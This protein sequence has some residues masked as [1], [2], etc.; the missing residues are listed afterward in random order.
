M[1][2]FYVMLIDEF[3]INRKTLNTYG[4][5]KRGQPGRLLIRTL[6]FKMSFIVAQS[7]IRFDGIIGTKDSFNQ[8]KYKIFLQELLTKFKK[9]PKVDLNNLIFVVDN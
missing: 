3:T 9:N 7:Q 6:E 2:K 4:W 5:T 8:M 1:K